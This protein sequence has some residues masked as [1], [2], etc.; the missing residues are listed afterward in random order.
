MKKIVVILFPFI[1]LTACVDSLDDYNV[2]QK[3]AST[4]P[5]ATL[6]TNAMKGLI[7]I[8]T[9]PSVNSNNYRMFVQYWTTTTYLD[10]PRYNMTSRT[11]SQNLWDAI[12]RDDLSDLKEAK[13]LITIDPFLDPTTKANQLGIIGIMEVYSWSVLV[14]TFGDVP[15]SQALDVNTLLPKYDNAETIYADLLTRLD[16]SLKMLDK[17]SESLG[18]ADIIYNGDVASWIK[19]GN[20]LKVKMAMVL[21]DKDGAKAKALVEAAVANPEGL[22][23]LPAS[24]VTSDP[25]T[26]KARF[27]YIAAAPNNNPISANLNTQFTSRE[28][29]IVANTIVDKMNTLND[30][31]RAQYFTQITG[32]YTGGK[33]GFSNTYANFS[34]PSAKII[35]PAFEGLFM[36]P[37]E[38][39]FFL[40]EAA[41]RGYNV[42][43]TAEQHYN[44]GIRASI[45][46]WGGTAAEVTA[47]LANPNV[48]YTTAA[49]DYR[50][51]IGTQKWIALFNR[52]WESWVE[53]RR[54]DQ[55]VLTPPTGN[56][57]PDGL[58]IP[59]RM[60]YPPTE[61]TLNG[62]QWGVA[63]GHLAGGQDTPNVKLFWDVN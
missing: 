59:V 56:G 33:Y 58:K 27:P 34:K 1:L 21:A 29:F 26:L 37:A 61:S 39:S 49:G 42:A 31:R 18:K 19:F 11:Y 53:W 22:I 52:G 55:P 47:Y 40:A 9:T 43:G 48:A 6:F 54:L 23:T 14:N 30:P 25:L 20:S 12:Y 62:T 15:Y 46:Y 51:K 45:L 60:I 2:D 32:A 8:L 28:D 38:I 13:R 5:P 41:E 17:T 57:A 10:E 44:A 3:K 63:V 36:E 24:D 16:A 35:A 50:Q 4:I 7:D